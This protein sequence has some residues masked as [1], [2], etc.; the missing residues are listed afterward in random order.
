MVW[1]PDTE[2]YDLFLR[3]EYEFRQA[4][5]GNESAETHDCADAF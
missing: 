3:G 1:T 2:A 4:R 5:R